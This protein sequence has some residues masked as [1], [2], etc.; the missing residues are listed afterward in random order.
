M[1]LGVWCASAMAYE[2]DRQRI[3][4][5]AD[6]SF[7]HANDQFDSFLRGGSGKLRF[8]ESDDGLRVNRIYLDYTGRLTDTISGRA[9]LN[10]NNDVEE[11][12]DVL[13]AY[14]EWR[15]VPKSKWRYRAKLGA[16]YPRLSVENVESG[17]SNAYALTSSAINTWIGEELRTI[18]A[19][20]R[21]ARDLTQEQQVSVEGAMFY[22]NDPT[23]ALLAWRGWA[24]HDRQTGIF[25]TIPLSEETSAI[26][27]WAPEGDP[28]DKYEPFEEIDNKA[29]FYGAAQWRWGKR[30]QIKYFHYDN[31]ADP[32]ARSGDVYAW[33]T[34]FD[35]IGLQLALPFKIGFLGQ[36]IEGISRMGEDL[37]PWRVQDIEF[38]S[39]FASLTRKFGDHRFTVRYE[40]FDTQP[41]NDPPGITNQD[42][43]NSAAVAWLYPLSA[44]LMLG[45]EYMQIR[46][47]HCKLSSCLWNAPFGYGLSQNTKES[48]VQLTV[49]WYFA[50]GPH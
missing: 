4:G 50:G 40:W 33:E 36:W 26:F 37:G 35:H 17:W 48:Q 13:E 3:S 20:V 43:G 18:G 5:A 42:T 11:A 38:E 47:D 21:I 46:T 25:G 30:I 15:P 19:E 9:V 27:P 41:Y 2:S 44:K 39:A 28:L 14:F 6:I 34:R 7:I 1:I 23:G 10:M 49:R 45:A 8:D 32:E 31:H 29:G 24:V 22:G 12:I 16:F